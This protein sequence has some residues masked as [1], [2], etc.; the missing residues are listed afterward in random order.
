MTFLRLWSKMSGIVLLL[1]MLAGLLAGCGEASKQLLSTAQPA[2]AFQTSAKTSDGR[3]LLLLSVNPNRLGANMFTVGV[4]E[5]SSGRPVTNI[6][7]RLFTTSLAM[8]MGTGT[9]YLEPDGNGHYSAQGGLSMNGRWQIGI[10]LQTSDGTQ[11]Y[12]TVM[13]YTS[14]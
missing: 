2:A 5:V 14:S 13:L 1:G 9:V 3:F 4:Q 7:V 12:A 10:Q 8:D 6:Q 11:H